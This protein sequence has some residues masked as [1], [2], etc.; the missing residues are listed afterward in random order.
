[1]AGDTSRGASSNMYWLPEWFGPPAGVLA[2]VLPLGVV[3]ARGDGVAVC[4]DHLAAYPAGFEVEIVTMLTQEATLTTLLASERRRVGPALREGEPPAEVLRFCVEYAD[5]T[6][7]TNVDRTLDDLRG[8]PARPILLD[9]GDRPAALGRAYRYWV[10]PL[11]ARGQILLGCEWP[12]AGIAPARVAVS[13]AD[14]VD[15]A[16]RAQVVLPPP[17]GSPRPLGPR[18]LG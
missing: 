18:P 6:V 13:A 4:A 15:A 7:V 9:L 8:R 12:A 14:I 17:D 1:M 10:W 3:L 5:G 11:P 2:G 16:A